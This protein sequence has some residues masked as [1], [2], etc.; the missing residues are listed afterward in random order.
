[1]NELEK[2]INNHLLSFPPQIHPGRM[3][4]C[5]LDSFIDFRS[6]KRLRSNGPGGTH[7]TRSAP[8]MPGAFTALYCHFPG[9]TIFRDVWNLEQTGWDGVHAST[10]FIVQTDGKE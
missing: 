5:I 8:C 7:H 3:E 6:S 2:I 4:F 10:V 9:V 1:M